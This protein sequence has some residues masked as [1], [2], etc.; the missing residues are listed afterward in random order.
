MLHMLCSE[1]CEWRSRCSPETVGDIPQRK[2]QLSAVLELRLCRYPCFMHWALLGSDDRWR[3][4]EAQG[5]RAPTPTPHRMSGWPHMAGVFYFFFC[6]IPPKTFYRICKM[7]WQ[8][9]EEK[10]EIRGALEKL[11]APAGIFT[12]FCFFTKNKHFYHICKM[13]WPKSEDKIE[14]GGPLRS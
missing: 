1:K 4:Q 5:A 11:G 2:Q 7:K 8:K 10:I 9:S 6:Q 12:F 3:S 14:I 13:K